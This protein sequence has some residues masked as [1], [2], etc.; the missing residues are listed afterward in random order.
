MDTSRFAI[1]LI[2][3]AYY[4]VASMSYARVESI[5]YKEIH[6]EYIELPTTIQV[7]IAVMAV[8]PA[9]WLPK[10]IERPSHLA[11]WML[12]ATVIVPTML[13]SFHIS[14]RPV[15]EI[16]FFCGFLLGLF[17]ILSTFGKL[18]IWQL[19]LPQV[20]QR[21]LLTVLIGVA[22][23][24]V[25]LTAQT[26]GFRLNLSLDNIYDRRLDARES[27]QGGA[28]SAYAIAI[29]SH[30][31]SPILFGL[32]VIERNAAAICTGVLGS[33][34]VFSFAGCKSD[35]LSLPLMLGVMVLIV[36]G[37]LT[38]STYLVFAW[39][40]LV[41]VSMLQFLILDRNDISLY[42]VRRLIFIPGLMSCIYWDF[43]SQNSQIWYGDSF[44]RWMYASPYDLPMARLI[45]ENYFH[46]HETNANANLWATSYGH[47]GYP[48]MCVATIIL[49][50]TLRIIDAL[51]V[52]CGFRLVAM[53]T[54][55]F[56]ISW[57][58]GSIETSMLSY[59]VLPSL[60]I[61]SLLRTSEAKPAEAVNGNRS[62]ERLPSELQHSP[63]PRRRMAGTEIPISADIG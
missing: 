5:L 34:C 45:G 29:L 63:P 18:S 27:V 25:F 2:A 3:C 48:G 28:L 22:F 33:L 46:S 39:T 20:R 51:S 35:L 56:A 47:C 59:G 38:P 30:S 37:R 16:V 44:L 61:F 17:A 24:L 36:R 49:G 54:A 6:L 43:F 41:L 52:T 8:A 62:V 40:G 7:F 19:R 9:L 11:L 57:S 50:L 21:P 42:F 60:V 12:Y 31:L 13:V 1:V 53:M 32:G 23:G 58:N 55:L 10:I 15:D 26:S 14:S 4:A